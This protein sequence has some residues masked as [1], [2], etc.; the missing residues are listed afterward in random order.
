MNKC[1]NLIQKYS[2]IKVKYLDNKIRSSKTIQ[3]IRYLKKINRD[4]K[5]I[6]ILGSDNLINF[7]KWEKWKEITK[8]AD[9]AILSRQGFDNRAKKSIAA[10]FL[11]KKNIIFVNNKKIN[12]SSS[13]L[14][15]NY[16]K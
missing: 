7:N 12:I 14:R 16:L 10:G 4:S 13:N 3:V 8:L 11:K 2:K 9:L 15:K 6:F 5:I 1:K